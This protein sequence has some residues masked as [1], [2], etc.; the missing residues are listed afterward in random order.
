MLR[1]FKDQN[2]KTK[3]DPDQSY[4]VRVEVKYILLMRYRNDN[5]DCKAYLPPGPAG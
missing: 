4:R 5:V 1:T 3:F 2:C